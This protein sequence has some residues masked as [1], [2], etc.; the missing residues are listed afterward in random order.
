VK[1]G[2]EIEEMVLC[3]N[4][5][6]SNKTERRHRCH[7]IVSGILIFQDVLGVDPGVLMLIV[8][9]AFILYAKDGIFDRFSMVSIFQ[10]DVS[11]IFRNLA[12]DKPSLLR[13]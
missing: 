9:A 11:H 7:R 6:I 12:F 8:R 3:D 1:I 13:F 4:F 10:A 2:A 5:V